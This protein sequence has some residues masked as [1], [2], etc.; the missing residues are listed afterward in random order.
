M[1]VRASKGGHTGLEKEDRCE[2]DTGEE[3]KG[4]EGSLLIGPQHTFF[5]PLDWVSGAIKTADMHM[6]GG[7]LGEVMVEQEAGA[8]PSQ[9]M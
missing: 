6:G 5:C 3:R 8:F 9:W 4:K 7:G 1:R 2:K